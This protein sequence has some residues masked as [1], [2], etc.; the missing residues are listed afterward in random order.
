GALAV[1]GALAFF[2]G[3]GTLFRGRLFGAL[4]G[5]VFG[6]AF[7]AGAAI[8]AL[9]GMNIQTYQRLTHERPVATVDVV[10]QGPQLHAVTVTQPPTEANPAGSRETYALHGD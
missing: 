9:T 8:I 6:G 5:V 1:I 4:P 10:Q 7:L 3:L 2:G